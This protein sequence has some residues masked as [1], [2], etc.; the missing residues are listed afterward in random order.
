M[1]AISAPNSMRV[2]GWSGNAGEQRRQ[3]SLIAAVISKCVR[4]DDLPLGV[5]RSLRMLGRAP[6]S[7]RTE[8]R[9]RVT[10]R[11]QSGNFI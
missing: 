1:G 11:P 9:R 8:I 2:Y 7:I 6:Y 5:D 3:L 4:Y 10:K